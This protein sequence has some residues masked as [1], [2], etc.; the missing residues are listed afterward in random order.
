M[1]LALAALLL[2]AIIAMPATVA[3]DGYR[4]VPFDPWYDAGYASPAPH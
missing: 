4:A 2:W 1:L 3:R